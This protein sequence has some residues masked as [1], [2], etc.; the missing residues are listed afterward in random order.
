MNALTENGYTA[1]EVARL[2]HAG[3]VE[4]NVGEKIYQ[5][6]KLKCITSELILNSMHITN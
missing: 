3:G 6:L 5:Y 1:A 4:N 2:Y